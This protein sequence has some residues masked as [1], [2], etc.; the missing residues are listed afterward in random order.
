MTK[1]E[2]MASLDEVFTDRRLTRA[3]AEE[4]LAATATAPVPI[5]GE[6]VAHAS[7]G[8]SGQRGVFV[9][10]L[11]GIAGFVLSAS[12]PVLARMQ[13]L[14]G[15]PP[16]GISIAMVAAG[17][18]VHMTGAAAAQVEGPEAPVRFL[19]APV[20]LP[21]AEIV[22]RLNEYQAL[23]LY[24][25]P[26]VL[27]RLAA[28]QRA[29]RLQIRPMI[30]TST[31]ETL[32]A[33]VRAS[34]T[35][36]FGAPVVD[37]FGS[38]EGLIGSSAPGDGPIA[39]N[40]DMCIVELV[41]EANRP[42]APGVASAKVLV[43]NLYNLVQPLIRYEL[44]DSFVQQAP[45]AEHGHLRAIVQGRMDEPFRYGEVE[46]HPHVV[47]SVL[48]RHP[49]VADYVVRQTEGGIEVEVL[50][51]AEVDVN[52]VSRE[53]AS[54]VEG[55]GMR[56]PEVSVRTVDELERDVKTGKLRRFVG[57]EFV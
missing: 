54:A 19:P 50:A 2:M 3:A 31:S 42:V 45:S 38:T 46:L 29:G 24:G 15:P 11:A 36:A 44:N 22:R 34:I 20:S 14:G 17:S 9:Y 16:G 48:V 55:A 41:D 51:L 27:S 23:G 49:E 56:V 33:E 18:A 13:A 12:R 40:T 10:D 39:F 4:A 21:L 30:I 43:T 6:F 32:T 35:E 5:F 52:E 57:C 8:S 1:A 28:E 37:T 7:G 47:R 53:L 26:S 25:Y